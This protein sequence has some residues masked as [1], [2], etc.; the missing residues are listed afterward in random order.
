MTAPEELAPGDVVQIGHVGPDGPANPGFS[1]CF[2]LVSE[3]RSWGVVGFVAMP[4]DREGPPAR[5]Y[6]RETHANLTR[7]GR[8]A[9]VP[10]DL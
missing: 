3:V 9:F 7:I 5:A 4:Q 1:G 2:M 6:Y 8:A 10:E